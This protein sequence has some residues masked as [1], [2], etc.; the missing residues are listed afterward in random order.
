MDKKLI[1]ALA[2]LVAIAGLAYGYIELQKR[3]PLETTLQDL[4]EDP[5]RYHGR[6]VVVE[7]F[8]FISWETI[9]LCKELELSGLAEGHLTPRGETI[10][11]EGGVSQEILDGLS[12]QRMIG[13]E[14]LYGKIRVKGRFEQGG[15]Y[16]HL[17]GFDFQITPIEVEVLRKAPIPI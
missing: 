10:W 11:V 8:L 6:T 15:S 16:G 14:E 13:L 1:I 2:S 5:R 4:L 12:S 3:K 9:V 17:G 7:G